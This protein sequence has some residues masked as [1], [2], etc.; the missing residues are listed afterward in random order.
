MKEIKFK[1]II[2]DKDDA[3]L[4][5]SENGDIYYQKRHEPDGSQ[6]IGGN[7]KFLWF[8]AEMGIHPESN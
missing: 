7:N 8:K 2:V 4:G 5:L 1:Q 3:L 6:V